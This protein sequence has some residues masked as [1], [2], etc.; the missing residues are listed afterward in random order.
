MRKRTPKNTL[1]RTDQCDFKGQDRKGKTEN[2]HGLDE[3][4]EDI[5]QLHAARLWL[6]EQHT[7]AVCRQSRETEVLCSWAKSSVRY[8]WCPGFDGDIKVIKTVTIIGASVNW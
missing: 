5:R 3:T 2:S 4:E 1:Q 7:R 6:L 8:Q